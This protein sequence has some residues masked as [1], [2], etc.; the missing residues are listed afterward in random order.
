MLFYLKQIRMAYLQTKRIQN[1]AILVTTKWKLFWINYTYLQGTSFDK[2]SCSSL[3][4]RYNLMARFRGITRF[5]RSQ[6]H[7]GKEE[8]FFAT[9]SF[10]DSKAS[11]LVLFSKISSVRFSHVLWPNVG[12]CFSFLVINIYYS[13]REI[14]REAEFTP[15]SRLW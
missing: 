8:P 2:K 14:L 13:Q 11:S 3:R 1:L 5:L 12:T 7:I 4:F 15:T 9:S 6:V 10:G